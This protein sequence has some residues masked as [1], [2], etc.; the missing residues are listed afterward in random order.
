MDYKELTKWSKQKWRERNTGYLLPR[1]KNSDDGFEYAK[2][3]DDTV[4]RITYGGWL[5]VRF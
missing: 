4:Y 3:S 5:R 2:A 1:K